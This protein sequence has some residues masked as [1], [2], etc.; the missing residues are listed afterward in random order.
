MRI[1]EPVLPAGIRQETDIESAIQQAL[2]E[3][4]DVRG[5]LFSGGELTGITPDELGGPVEFRECVFENWRFSSC[6]MPHLGFVDV[7]FRSC[8]LSN[9]DLTGGSL[10]RCRFE[11]CKAVGLTLAEAKLR[12]VTFE[13]CGMRLANLSGC[14]CK[15]VGFY[16]C[17][18]EGAAMLGLR[19]GKGP[20]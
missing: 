14:K 20:F 2:R 4:D 9:L 5:C 6:A 18:L 15:N 7:V 3:E 1:Q 12:Q 19:A 8:D 11:A 17:D 16:R 13:Q 10:L